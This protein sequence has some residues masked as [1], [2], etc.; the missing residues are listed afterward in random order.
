[1]TA[2][3]PLTQAILISTALHSDGAVFKTSS[4]ASPPY[5]RQASSR[6]MG[7]SLGQNPAPQAQL[8]GPVELA[9][10]ARLVIG[11]MTGMAP[12]LALRLCRGE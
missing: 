3:G 12:A 1:V 10:S 5:W 4:S 6:E 2:S 7:T 9:P 8:T 11:L